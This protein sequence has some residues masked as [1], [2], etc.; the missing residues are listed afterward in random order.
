YL[1]DDL[2]T[3]FLPMRV[4]YSRCLAAGD[5]CR[6]FPQYFC[7]FDLHGEGQ[8]GLLHPEHLALYGLLP[9]TIAYPT[10]FLLN[11]AGLLAGTYLFLRR[12]VATPAAA[13]FGAIAFTFFGFNTFHFMHIHGIT[14]IA[15]LP[16]SLWLT[17]LLFRGPLTARGGLWVGCGLALLTG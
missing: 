8:M 7:G 17:D 11:Y 16:F 14:I 4:F 3:V 6:W 2:Y 15:H 10:E 9:L 5:D 13:V 1:Y 12:W